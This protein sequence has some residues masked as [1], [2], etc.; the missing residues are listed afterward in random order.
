MITEDNLITAYAAMSDLTEPLCS[1]C[2]ISNYRPDTRCCSAEY[3]GF[4]VDW[5]KSHWNEDIELPDREIPF[6][7]KK[8]CELGPHYRPMCTLHHCS[9]VSLG[10]FLNEKTNGKYWTLRNLINQLEATKR[11]VT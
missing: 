7:G 4:A 9:I 6:L 2:P 5:A 11:M 8:G 3:C 10:F 1:E